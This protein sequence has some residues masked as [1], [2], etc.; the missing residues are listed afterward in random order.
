MKSFDVLD[1]RRLRWRLVLVCLCVL[2]GLVGCSDDEKNTSSADVLTSDFPSSSS[3]GGDADVAAVSCD[4]STG[5]ADSAQVCDPDL[6]VCVDKCTE[7]SCEF[8]EVC[9]LVSGACLQGVACDSTT[10]CADS[11]QSCD[12][13]RGVCIDGEGKTTC[14]SNMNCRFEEYCDSCTSL[15]EVRKALCEECVFDREC[16]DSGDRCIDIISAEGRFCGQACGSVNDCPDGYLCGDGQCVPASGDCAVPSECAQDVDCRGTD[17]ICDR[18]RCRPGCDG[19]GSCPSELVCQFGRCLEACPT[20]ACDGETLCNTA[21]GLCEIE[22]QCRES[23]DCPDA[24]TYCDPAT[25]QCVAGCEVDN[26][27]L[28]VTKACEGGACVDRGCTAARQCAFEQVCDLASGACNPAMGPYCEA[29]DPND[30]SACGSADNKC[31]ELQDEEGNSLGAFCF[32]ACDADPDNRCPSGYQCT[33]LEDQNG[34]PSG[35]VCFRDCNFDPWT[36]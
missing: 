12:T 20:R 1:L 21:N 8:G 17:N 18:G 29:C 24:V 34:N 35:E 30:D 31:L 26:D 2:I 25:S 9:D 27:C 7:T 15:C 23:A 22:G 16:G 13:C 11:T 5:C 6:L 32:V 28:D 10:P 19:P 33:P 3:S 36:P 14:D 4:F